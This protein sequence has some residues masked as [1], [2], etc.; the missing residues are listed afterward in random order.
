VQVDRIVPVAE[1]AFTQAGFSVKRVREGP[2]LYRLEVSHGE[3]VTEV[4]FGTDFRLLPME[5]GPLGPT[6]G[7][8]E[9]A[10]DDLCGSR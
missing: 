2:G 1:E 10:I 6:L 3:D 9:L 4:D 7:G 8:E 5:Q